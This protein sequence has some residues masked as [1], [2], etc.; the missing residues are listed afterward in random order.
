MMMGRREALQEAR[1][2][3]GPDG[4]VWEQGALKSVGRHGVVAGKKRLTWVAGQAHTWEEAFANADD[5]A[6]T[7]GGGQQ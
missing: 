5:R 6:I 7:D 1:R 3:W 2:R 4:G